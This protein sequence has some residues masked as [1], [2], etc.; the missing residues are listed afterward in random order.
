MLNAS[1]I[2]I[3]FLSGR[4]NRRGW[5]TCVEVR[6][7]FHISFLQLNFYAGLDEKAD[8]SPISK[9]SILEACQKAYEAHYGL[10]SNICESAFP[11]MSGPKRTITH[12]ETGDEHTVNPR[13]YYPRHITF[14]K[15]IRDTDRFDP[16]IPFW[17]T[18]SKKILVLPRPT[19][20]QPLPITDSQ[21]AASPSVL[22]L[23][24]ESPIDE[25]LRQY[26]RRLIGQIAKNFPPLT[27]LQLEQLTHVETAFALLCKMLPAIIKENLSNQDAVAIAVK[28]R[29]E[30]IKVLSNVS[31][32]VRERYCL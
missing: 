8:Y 24:S 30:A 14:P 12:P 10:A 9:R 32:L 16:M 13:A 4:K 27:G 20:T 6:C 17:R 26:V 23:I 21:Y 25:A 22:Q 1:L 7:T 5:R 3:Y 11:D 2:W 29:L 31:Y 15:Y 28:D 19:S 18:Y